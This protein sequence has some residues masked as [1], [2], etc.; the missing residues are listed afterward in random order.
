MTTSYEI[1]SFLM[2]V[3][4]TSESYIQKNIYDSDAQVTYEPYGH[5]IRLQVLYCKK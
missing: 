3:D 1:V 5:L 2:S 4:I